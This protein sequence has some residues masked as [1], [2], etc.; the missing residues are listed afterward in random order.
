[1]C[2]EKSDE[3]S[4]RDFE[5]EYQAI[6]SLSLKFCQELKNQL[7]ELLE[8]EQISLAF[9]IE[10]RVKEWPSLVGKIEGKLIDISSIKEVNDLIGLRIILLFRSD[11]TKTFQIIEHNFKI[12]EM[13]D[14]FK[15]LREN[16]FGYLSVHYVIELPETW[17][18]IPSFATLH[19]FKAEVQVRTA[20]QHIW[21]AASHKLQ[22]KKETGVPI[23]VRRSIHRVSALL[24]TVDLEL[25]R[26]LG[27]RSDYLHQVDTSKD[28]EPL[29]VDLM[30]HILST[31]LPPQN[32]DRNIENI[33]YAG[34]LEDLL[35]FKI[36]TPRKLIFLLK[37]HL[38][39]LIRF[40]YEAVISD[41]VKSDSLLAERAARGVYFT[42]V[43]LTRKA[44]SFEF[45]E[46]WK[47][48]SKKYLSISMKKMK[49]KTIKQKKIN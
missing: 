32:K 1:M 34:L 45:G 41:K 30:E 23:P 2:P 13:D 25:D 49:K 35:Y 28:N 21:A 17:F 37:K 43:G 38:D 15:R 3:A 29:N 44:L 16:E 7:I 18:A 42:Q 31:I 39:E 14:T 19:G 33:A 4:L 5:T 8:Q 46:A 11:L 36:D 12:I 40:D 26:V 6:H 24:E 20:A 22:Y 48:Y 27:E 47:T 9:P 10:S